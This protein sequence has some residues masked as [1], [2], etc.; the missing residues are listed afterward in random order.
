[1]TLIEIVAAALLLVGSL[2]VI[3]AV[4]V[5]DLSARPPSENVE[6]EAAASDWR[7]AA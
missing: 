4:V 2:L 6:Q 3:R 7:R 5:S 1:V